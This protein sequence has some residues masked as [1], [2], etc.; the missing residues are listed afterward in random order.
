MVSAVVCA[1]IRSSMRF[2]KCQGC[3]LTL[4]HAHAGQQPLITWHALV[5]EAKCEVGMIGTTDRKHLWLLSREPAMDSQ[6]LHKLRD[7]GKKFGCYAAL[8][9]SSPVSGLLRPFTGSRVCSPAE[10]E[11]LPPY[12]LQSLAAAAG[13]APVA[14]G[15][16]PS[17]QRW[18]F[19]A[20]CHQLLVYRPW[21]SGRTAQPCAPAPSPDFEAGAWPP[22]ILQRCLRLSDT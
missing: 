18:R 22:G 21:S 16:A 6:S 7:H 4:R 19:L 1:R 17:R 2:R 20:S 12:R 14:T 10:P 15:V 3:D 9:Q 8:R 11:L 5:V 13:P